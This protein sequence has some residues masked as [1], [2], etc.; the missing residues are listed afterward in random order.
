MPRQ[1]AAMKLARSFDAYRIGNWQYYDTLKDHL[2]NTRVTFAD[3]NGDESIDL[4]E[5]VVQ[6]NHFYAFG[7]T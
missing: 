1:N 3:K 5:E 6:I 4:R 7:A 2:G